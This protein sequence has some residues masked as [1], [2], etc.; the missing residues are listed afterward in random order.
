[1]DFLFFVFLAESLK[2]STKKVSKRLE[3]TPT[4][5]KIEPVCFRV[6]RTLFS[7][8]LQKTFR[9]NN[10][11]ELS[12][13]AAAILFFCCPDFWFCPFVGLKNKVG[14]SS[15][16][17]ARRISS[18]EV[19]AVCRTVRQRCQTISC[20]QKRLRCRRR[21]RRRRPQVFLS[22]CEKKKL[23]SQWKV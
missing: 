6:M 9:S 10:S 22:Q 14:W 5:N 1:M 2:K 18:W 15:L 17:F 23:C 4:R 13:Y 20:R 16:N 8:G 12:K 7:P 11:L 21:L 3:R 19:D